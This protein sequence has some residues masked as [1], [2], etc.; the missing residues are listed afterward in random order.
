MTDG[1]LTAKLIIGLH[2]L[3]KFYNFH[4][5]TINQN[6]NT[7]LINKTHIKKHTSPHPSLVQYKAIDKV[8]TNILLLIDIPR[9]NVNK[10]E[11]YHGISRL[12]FPGKSND[13]FLARS[14]INNLIRRLIIQHAWL[15]K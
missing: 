8:I 7:K 2:L 14:Q 4:H 9:K 3:I 10:P 12:I 6:I 1:Y 15:K 5:G 11:L 13:S